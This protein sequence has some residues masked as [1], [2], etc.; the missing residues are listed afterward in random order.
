MSAWN[1]LPLALGPALPPVRAAVLASRIQPGW[2]VE[3]ACAGSAVDDWFPTSETTPDKLAATLAVCSAC[4]VRRSCLAFALLG[5]E[6]GIWGGTTKNQRD[7]ALHAVAV[8]EHIDAVLDRF[9]SDGHA[10][11]KTQRVGDDHSGDPLDRKLAD[12]MRPARVSRPWPWS[13]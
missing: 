4:P 11:H 3:A 8:G 7:Q 10:A 2:Q 13:R 5:Q 1:E 12:V 6:Y 9:G